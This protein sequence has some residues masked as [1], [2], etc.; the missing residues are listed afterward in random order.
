M[1]LHD[2][3]LN[4]YSKQHCCSCGC[5]QNRR[6]HSHFHF[7]SSYQQCARTIWYIISHEQDLSVDL[8]QIRW[9]DTRKLMLLDR[10]WLAV[11]QTSFQRQSRRKYPHH[12]M[13]GGLPGPWKLKKVPDES[14]VAH[15]HSG[16]N[17][18]DENSFTKSVSLNRGSVHR[19]NSS[20]KW[21]VPPLPNIKAIALI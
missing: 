19:H 7:K 13:G 1:R 17:H 2:G 14:D 10:T 12:L 16:E 5:S 18:T 21:N 9:L 8:D 3:S 11:G 20:P 6:S 4:W 15:D